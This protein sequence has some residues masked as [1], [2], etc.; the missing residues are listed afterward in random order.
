MTCDEFWN[1]DAS[2]QDHLNECAAC[3]AQFARHQQLAA[4]LQALGAEMRRVEAPARVERGLVSAFR[5]QRAKSAMRSQGA[6]WLT[7]AWAAA[8][9]ATA[10]LA[11]ALVRPHQ[12]PPTPARRTVRSVTQLASMQSPA[13]A[14]IAAADFNSGADGFVPL[15]NAEVVEPNEEV[16][17]VRIELPRSA[18]IPLGYDVPAERAA[19]TVEADVMLDAD[20]VARAVRFLE[21]EKTTREASW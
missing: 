7:G 10:L 5:A 17:V 14:A 18:M 8:L 13:E 19:E 6:W 20:G 21:I 1:N 9:T 15:P 2:A 12:P 11:V 16:N 4:G 3:A